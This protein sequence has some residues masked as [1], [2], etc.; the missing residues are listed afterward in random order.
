MGLPEWAER[1][2]RKY[3]PAAGFDA[4]PDPEMLAWWQ[5][6]KDRFERRWGDIAPEK[7][8]VPVDAPCYAEC[9]RLVAWEPADF[10]RECILE[11]AIDL[12]AKKRDG[13]SPG[14]VAPAVKEL[15]SLNDQIATKASELAYLFRQRDTIRRDHH[16]HDNDDFTVSDPFGFFD[17]LEGAIRIPRVRR[18]VGVAHNEIQAFLQVARSQ[19]REKPEWPDL[20]DQISSRMPRP[21]APSFAA[22]AAVK[23][24]RTKATDWSPWGVWLLGALDEWNEFPP[25]FLRECLGHGQ[26][27]TLAEVALD[28][29]AGAFNESQMK[30]LRKR[31]AARL[32]E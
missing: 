22:D 1:A 5:Q 27:A 32:R 6:C 23:A 29:P 18:W 3:E 12:A 31:Y 24:S 19:S 9:R 21:A 2:F 26:L 14:K 8:K 17:A 25:G 16:I 28:A 20:L 13:K 4:D 11:T 15:D 7:W 30:E 10:V